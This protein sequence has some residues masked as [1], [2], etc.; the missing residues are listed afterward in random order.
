MHLDNLKLFSGVVYTESHEW[1]SVDGNIG[2]VG[3]T[4][5][6]QKELGEIVY[7]ELP[8]IGQLIKSGDEVCVLESTK[9]AVDVY[10]PVS[11][12]I[13]AINDSLRE[14]PSSVNRDAHH[15]GWLFQVKLSHPTECKH[16][17]TISQYEAIQ[18]SSKV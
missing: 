17:L 2:T 12:E 4:N 14:S 7:I 13:V 3:I 11:G 15:G 16:L 10:S 9:A 18:T 5:Y 8:K 1:V 6:A